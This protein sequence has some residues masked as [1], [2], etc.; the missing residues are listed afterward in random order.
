MH[1]SDSQI[2]QVRSLIEPSIEAM[3][4]KLVQVRIMGGSNRPTLQIMAEPAD[5]SDMDVDDCAEI[6]RTVSALLDVEDPIAGAYLLE[7]SSPGIDR[8][9]VTPE[10]FARFSGFEAKLESRRMLAG[11]RRFNGQ[12]LGER[13][14]KVHIAVTGLGGEIKEVAIPF[15]DIAN[16]KLVLTDELIQATLKKRKH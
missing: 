4:F 1:V 11:Q 10:D 14:G 8:P 6:S 12:L 15:A 7:V 5:G 2:D 3:G 16:A 9:L 13:N